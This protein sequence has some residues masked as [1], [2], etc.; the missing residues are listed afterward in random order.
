M[1]HSDDCASCQIAP[2]A[3]LNTAIH[4]HRRLR[5]RVHTLRARE[6]FT[7]RKCSGSHMQQARWNSTISAAAGCWP[8]S[9]SSQLPL[10]RCRSAAAAAPPPKPLR[11]MPTKQRLPEVWVDPCDMNTISPI[12]QSMCLMCLPSGRSAAGRRAVPA[13]CG[14]RP[15]TERPWDTWTSPAACNLG[16]VSAT[17]KAQ[18]APQTLPGPNHPAERRLRAAER[19]ARILDRSTAV[20]A[21]LGSR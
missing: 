19:P 1:G 4:R 15:S 3:R 6:R 17:A 10:P 16:G 18:E 8:L 7:D 20:S 21:S 11:S 13:A 9:C 12:D 2:S 14:S 5:R